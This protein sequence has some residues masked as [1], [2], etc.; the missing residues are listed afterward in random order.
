MRGS[1]ALF[2]EYITSETLRQHNENSMGTEEQLNILM[3]DRT[4]E[5]I[6][7]YLS[8]LILNASMAD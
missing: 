4:G 1:T 7:L 8:N 5:R 3:P 6:V 2:M